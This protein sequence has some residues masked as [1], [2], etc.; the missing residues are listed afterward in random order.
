M[1]SLSWRMDTLN[2]PGE[3]LFNKLRLNIR[4]LNSDLTALLLL[5]P[6]CALFLFF[7]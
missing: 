5:L 3:F 1:K 6:S 7:V 2:I 4:S